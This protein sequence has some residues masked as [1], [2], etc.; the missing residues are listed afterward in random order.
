MVEPLA[1]LASILMKQHV[2]YM[3]LSLAVTTTGDTLF[4]WDSLRSSED[5]L[6]T[7]VMGR[8]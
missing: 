8:N 5:S 1:D 6:V 2:L 3:L 4:Q 7:F